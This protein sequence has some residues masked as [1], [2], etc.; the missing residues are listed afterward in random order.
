MEARGCP[1]WIRGSINSSGLGFEGVLERFGTFDCDRTVP[2]ARG[3]RLGLGGVSGLCLEG[4]GV[5][6][7]RRGAARRQFRRP[8]RPTNIPAISRLF[9]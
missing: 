2:D 1:K 6:R 3:G 7:E 5:R 8:K 4:L 9:I